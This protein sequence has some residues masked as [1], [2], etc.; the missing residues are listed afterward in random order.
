M[1]GRRQLDVMHA[2]NACQCLLLT[3]SHEGSPNVVKEAMACNLPVVSTRVG[4]VEEHFEGC[5]GHFLAA[6]T[7]A[8]LAEGLDKAILHGRTQ[9]ANGFSVCR[10]RPWRL[11]SMPS[12]GP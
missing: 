6:A 7:P 2:M 3:S 9:A 10:L 5:P 1:Q 11:E 4:D 8:D 12:T